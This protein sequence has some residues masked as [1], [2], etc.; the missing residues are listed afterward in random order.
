MSRDLDDSID[1]YIDDSIDPYIDD[2]IDVSLDDYFKNPL[3]DYLNAPDELPD[4][5]FGPYN[6]GRESE[7]PRRDYRR[8]WYSDALYG[9]P[10]G[11]GSSHAPTTPAAKKSKRAPDTPPTAPNPDA[12]S[13]SNA[14]TS[15]SSALGNVSLVRDVESSNMGRSMS[16]D[17]IPTRKRDAA[18]DHLMTW[19]TNWLNTKF[20]G[21][22]RQKARDSSEHQRSTEPGAAVSHAAAEKRRGQKHPRTQ[23]DEDI[24]D[25]NGDDPHQ[26]SR[27]LSK[28]EQGPAPRYACPFFKHDPTKYQGTQWKSCCWPGWI[29]IHRV[30]EHLFRRHLL[31]KFQCSRCTQI[32]D[33]ADDLAAH[34]REN[35][36]CEIVPQEPQDGIS[37]KQKESLRARG[38]SKGRASEKW[39]EFYQI[40]FPGEYPVP[41]PFVEIGPV[42]LDIKAQTDDS[43]RQFEEYARIQFPTVVHPVLDNMIDR[44][45]QRDISREAFM[46]MVE[47]AVMRIVEDF[48][49]LD[50]S[51][52]DQSQTPVPP[53]P[54]VR[55]TDPITD[56]YG[57][58]LDFLTEQPV[59]P[60]LNFEETLEFL[61]NGKQSDSGY[62]SGEIGGA[63]VS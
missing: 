23:S 59:D 35:V 18:V 2:Y 42:N 36:I 62:G 51:R 44:I 60:C 10:S 40:L 32:L 48:R 14:D 30:K 21:W 28:D 12:P 1:P 26:K 9:G 50:R 56:D 13:V 41:S 55:E 3:D 57:W 54:E 63:S 6:S 11:G 45:H 53:S 38:K 19:S 43:F 16:P 29:T 25:S 17:E 39:S 5:W 24:S 8:A 46:E 4:R 15:L 61:E 58:F 37:E 52:V 34:L 20:K 31:P 47:G 22:A 27:K 49:L 7:D 33:S